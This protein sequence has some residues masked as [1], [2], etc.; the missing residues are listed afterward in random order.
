MATLGQLIAASLGIDLRCGEPV[1]QNIGSRVVV[2]GSLSFDIDS[3]PRI[4]AGDIKK[5]GSSLDS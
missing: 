2:T 3:Y 4:G 1:F 5:P